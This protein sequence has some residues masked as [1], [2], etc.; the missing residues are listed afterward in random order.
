LK[1]KNLVTAEAEKKREGGASKAGEFA[2]GRG[3][4][5]LWAGILT[6]PLVFLLHLQI[7]YA[8]VTQLCQSEHKI[9]M[10]LVTLA[11]ILISAGGGLIAFLNW[12]DAGRKWP[13]EA[14]SV[15]ERS[16]FM[17]V[18]GLLISLLVILGL[19][20]QLLPQFIFDPCQR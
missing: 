11:A 1:G 16:R 6:A 18:V 19:I 5:R 9:A 10:H 4:A 20:A 3:K 8:L 2:Q 15:A 17:S 7:N 13:G 14:G 12:R